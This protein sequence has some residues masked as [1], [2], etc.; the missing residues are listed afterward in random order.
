MS[1]STSTDNVTLVSSDGKEFKVD[2][3]AAMVSGTIRAML[4]GPGMFP[5][6]ENCPNYL[7]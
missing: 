5:F 6:L 4:S 3:Q 7:F 1:Q 2:R